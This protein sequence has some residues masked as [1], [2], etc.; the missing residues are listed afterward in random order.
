MRFYEAPSHLQLPK[1]LDTGTRIDFA[2]LDGQHLFDY[3]LLECFYVDLMLPVGGVVA[4]DDPWMDSVRKAA[5]FLVRNRRYRLVNYTNRLLRG[6]PAPA[7][8]RNTIGQL[9]NHPWMARIGKIAFRGEAL[10]Y[11]QKIRQD[12]RP[13]DWHRKF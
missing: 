1:L 11:L 13:W 4:L 12:D 6:K 5:V 2:F 8:V 9:L 7:W 3:V 10:L